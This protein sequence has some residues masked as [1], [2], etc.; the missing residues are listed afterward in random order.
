MT[1]IPQ[2]QGNHQHINENKIALLI[3]GAVVIREVWCLLPLDYDLIYPFPMDRT[4]GLTKQAYCCYICHY[5]CLLIIAMAFTLI[6]RRN[7]RIAIVWFN[8]QIIEFIDYFYSD[9][10]SWFH[11]FDIGIGITI[12]KL[13]IMFITLYQEFNK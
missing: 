10:T 6:L 7:Q 9:N 8:L 11:I 2:I 5:A 12:C 3:F 1:I 4:I 13:I